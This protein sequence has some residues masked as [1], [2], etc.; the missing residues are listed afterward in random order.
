MENHLNNHGTKRKCNFRQKILQWI[1][2]YDGIAKHPALRCIRHLE[3][4][5]YPR[6]C[7]RI[8]ILILIEVNI[9]KKSVAVE[10]CFN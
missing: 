5:P 4:H 7:P 8:L 10:K 3:I 2:V 9:Y 6:N 1:M